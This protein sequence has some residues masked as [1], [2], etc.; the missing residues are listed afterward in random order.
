MV[1]GLVVWCYTRSLLPAFTAFNSSHNQLLIIRL[2]TWLAKWLRSWRFCQKKLIESGAAG[3]KREHRFIWGS[4]LLGAKCSQVQKH[5][6]ASSSSW[7]CRWHEWTLENSVL[8][9][10]CMLGSISLTYFHNQMSV[11]FQ[12]ICVALKKIFF[13]LIISWNVIRV[14][15]ECYVLLPVKL[16]HEV[17]EGPGVMLTHVK[18][19]SVTLMAFHHLDSGSWLRSNPPQSNWYRV[20]LIALNGKGIA[21]HSIV[22][23]T[24]KTLDR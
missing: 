10:L 11:M 24:V 3:G 1:C 13:M 12:Q 22:A 20:L 8:F 14:R 18:Y 19:S 16:K 7:A 9:K 17:A 23:V 15:N 5:G 2:V 4:F 6:W 21:P